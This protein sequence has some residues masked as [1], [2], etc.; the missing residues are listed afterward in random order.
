[1]LLTLALVSP[2][3]LQGQATIG[4]EWRADVE[5]FAQRIVEAGLT[6]GMSV[7]VARGDWVVYDGGFGTADLRTGRPA[8]TATQFYIASTTKSLTA[9]AVVLAADRGQLDL[10]APLT[11]YV[12]DA[13]LPEGASPEDV[14]LRRL[15]TMTHGLDGQGPIVLLTAYTGDYDRARLPELLR[16]HPATG[17]AGVFS[18]NNLGYNL[19]ALALEAVNGE[20]WKDVVRRDVLEPLGMS[21][22]SAYRSRL[23]PDRIAYPHG[24]APAAP[25]GEADD[26]DRAFERIRLIKDDG[27]LHAAGGHFTTAGDLARYVA[28]H[29]GGGTLGGD[30]VLPEGPVLRTHR[31]HV[32]QDRDFGPYH[33]FGWGFGWDLATVDGDTILQ[34]FG[35]F[36]GYRSHMSFMPSEDLGVVVLVNG[37]GPASPASDLMARYVYD[38]LRGRA[39]LEATYDRRLVELEARAEQA[40]RDLADHRRER[41]ARMAP[42]PHP[43]EA[44]AGTYVN[45]ALGRITWRVVAGGLEA[46]IGL[47]GARAEVYDAAE[48]QLR[49][50]L[51]GGGTVVDFAFDADGGPAG[52]LEI[53][54]FTFRRAGS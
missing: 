19:L 49:V 26:A 45:D 37:G 25:E 33:R 22:T 43:L 40:R 11:R 44:Y 39:D 35:G 6:P 53:L 24:T 2:L 18:Y 41:A 27:N 3:G 15:L 8:S 51:T 52:S 7:A 34:R 16:L 10:D 47:L 17:E 38:R 48:D 5:A 31:M 36:A 1:M 54:G 12:P 32:E 42:L 4:G 9:L 14:T 46:H 20:S 28:A 50:E 13:R 21:G 23:D 29:L 30:R